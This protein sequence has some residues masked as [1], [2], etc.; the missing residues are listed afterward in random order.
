[1]TLAAALL[2]LAT[3]TP[4]PQGDLRL[5]PPS[6]T[7]TAPGAQRPANEVERFRRDLLD[8][9][10]AEPRVEAKLQEV[11]VAYPA[12]EPLILEVARTA[13]PAEMLNLLV[14]A[15][16]FGNTTGTSR[17]ADEL[18]FQ[19]LARPLGDATR[20]TVEA[21]VA[22]KGTDAKKALQDCVRGRIAGVR[23]AATDVLVTMATAEDL[24]FAL[25]L[26]GDASLDL[27]L[28][29]V[30]LLAA[31]PD[32]RAKVRLV[33][34]LSKTPPLAAAACG[35]LVR[36]GA[37]A[38][39][40]LQQLCREPA[41]DR[42]FAYAAFA[43]AEIGEATATSCLPDELAD[44][45]VPQ[46]ASPESLTRSLAAIPLADLAYRGVAGRTPS[47]DAAIVEALIDVV[48]P[49]QFVP[50]LDSLRRPA[51][52]RLLRF[53]GR[54]IAANEVLPWREWWKVQKEGFVGMRSHVAVD[55]KSA[56]FA[57]VVL[58]QGQRHVRLIAEG[59]AAMPPLE[60]A[61][62]VLLSD[63]QMLA[64][65]EGLQA[66]GFGDPEVLRGSSG[67][68]P[69]R[70][71]QI[72]VRGGRAQVAV[73][74]GEHPRF[75]ALVKLVTACVDEEVWQLYR[76]PSAEPDRGAFWRAERRWLDSNPDPVERGRRFA[77][78]LVQ[79]WSTLSPSL[80]ARGVE[81]VV[82]HPQRR[83]LLGE[84]DGAAAVAV[85]QQAKELG[86]LDLR[87]L[88]L[89]ASVPGDRVWRDC[90]GLAAT[91][92]GG[93]RAAVRSVFAV[94]GPDAVL[95]ALN[96][97]KAVVRRAALE[98][99]VVVRDPRAAPR[100]LQLLADADPDVRRAAAF[101][102]G[103]LQIA[104][105]A[106]PLIATIA[107]ESTEPELRRE[108]LRALGR[109]GGDQAFA[110][111]QRALAAPQKEDKE[112]AL[113]GLGELKDPRAAQLLAD[114]VVV[115]N[116]KDIGELSRYYLQ[117]MGG[118]LA[119]PALRSQVT[120]VQD[121]AIREQLVLL[122]G[123]YQDPAIV[124]DLIDLLR[125]PKLSLEASGLLACTTGIDVANATDRIGTIEA[126]WRKNRQQ[127]QW[128][129]LLDALRAAQEPTTLRPEHFLADAGLAAVGELARLLTE[130]KQPRL[131][132]L[133]SAVL[134]SVTN[135]DYGIV[136][137]QT[138]DDVL[139]GI[140]GR[141]RVLVE[142]AKAAQGK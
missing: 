61:I 29:G 22:L 93:G 99:V 82:A 54:V 11:A 90:V 133:C 113:R 134:R 39:P 13:K 131:R 138:P 114:L 91:M 70:S 51:E 112:A 16:R 105:A 17:V 95:A 111:L 76:N 15:R 115:G 127:Q 59:L 106:T 67:L 139:A 71:L 36:V 109:T 92:P 30:D 102:C 89:A 48:T 12:I 43:L 74:A 79:Q 68:P 81:H 77:H 86:E 31:V 83:Q 52:Q 56:S 69:A 108:C 103:Q 49:Q 80:R 21:M 10:G 130:A 94:L 100:I 2:C 126:W 116:G 47:P 136:T 37:P 117:R 26:S 63:A 42:G 6:K 87:L 107:K 3:T 98:E 27:Q 75:E 66:A 55:A 50:N 4:L 129:W 96:D 78:R 135:E 85:L 41:I 84:D 122:L 19:L 24:A 132:V 65:V 1:M 25:Q 119:V 33:E 128:Q 73:P 140:A 5:P 125:S 118:T 44:T 121:P 18:L 124:P 110:V 28:R 97:D 9:Q 32:D 23:R 104:A 60:G 45:L 7:T 8:M 38:V 120:V 141:Y 58:R 57:I 46:L 14:V 34:L 53:S 20:P 40:Q 123:L 72:Q 35:A 137:P 64:L 142:A 62:E 101:A 88:E